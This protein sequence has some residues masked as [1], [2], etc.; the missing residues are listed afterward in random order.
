MA[1]R[2]ELTRLEDAVADIVATDDPGKE[3]VAR[4]VTAIVGVVGLLANDLGRIAN[5]LEHM[6]QEG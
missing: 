1:T 2:I 6:R 3:Q 5:A 4:V